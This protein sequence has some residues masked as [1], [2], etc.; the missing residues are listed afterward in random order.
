M[1][2][3]RIGQLINNEFVFSILLT[4]SLFLATHIV[5]GFHFGWLDDVLQ[6]NYMRGIAIGEPQDKFFTAH[7]LLSKLYHVLYIK[8]PAVAWYGVFLF[9][10][11]FLATFFL[12]YF[13]ANR[14]HELFRSRKKIF[15]ALCLCI[16]GGVW[17][18]HVMLLNY[19]RLSILLAGT[20]L[21]LIDHVVTSSRS[22]GKKVVWL[23]VLSICLLVGLLTRPEIIL[24]LALP[25]LFYVLRHYNN[26]RVLAGIAVVIATIALVFVVIYKKEVTQDIR[27]KNDTISHILNITDARN[28][29]LK[30][31]G[32]LIGEDI[33]YKAVYFY[34]FPDDSLVE[35]N[36]L[37]TWGPSGIF[38]KENVP[39]IFPR[40]KYELKRAA[41]VYSDLYARPLNWLFPFLAI[42]LINLVILLRAVVY[43][44]DKI[45]LIFPALVLTSY[46]ALTCMILALVKLEGR[47]AMPSLAIISLLTIASTVQTLHS[48][49][50]RKWIVMLAVL[51]T[52]TFYQLAAY[53]SIAEDRKKEEVLKVQFIQ[54]INTTFKGK[55]LLFDIWT[56][57]LLHQSPFQNISLRTD[58]VYTNHKEYWSGF[59]PSHVEHLVQLCGDTDFPAFY[60]CLFEKGEE[61]VFVFTKGNRIGL[62]EEYA[63]KTHNIEVEFSEIMTGSQL[64]NI[65]YSFLP[66][67]LDFG[68]FSLKKVNPIPVDPARLPEPG[69]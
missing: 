56:M 32:R 39:N 16:Y 40:I 60:S 34:Y 9:S 69:G 25:F 51:V 58:N 47:V 68:Y 61:V 21:L 24:V 59:L 7:I 52:F 11:S 33:G 18:E 54:E 64:G 42:L 15:L 41:T 37:S 20:A 29:G 63:W 65:H 50:L 19:T 62:I 1:P 22:M 31:F 26:P 43:S 4:V 53:Y 66:Y 49:T 27:S 10:Y 2:A 44:N 57:S 36:S 46:I 8:F 5:F 14:F 12:F 6:S 17:M 38:T 13:L 23:S 55:I 3:K 67:R 45:R 35:S 28:T 48:I 30:S